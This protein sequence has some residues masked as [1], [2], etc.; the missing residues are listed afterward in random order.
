MPST[1]NNTPRI[2][3][4]MPM[5]W[6]VRNVVYSGILERLAG[7]GIQV[8]LL[9]RGHDVDFLENPAYA[10]FSL[11]AGIE[12][13]LVPPIRV[14]LK[15]RS[16]LKQVIQS[17]FYQRNKLRGYAIYRRW[18]ERHYTPFQRLRALAVE[19]LGWLAKPLLIF[20]GLNNL[21]QRLY[22]YEY[23]LPPIA[24]QLQEIAPDLI[25]STVNVDP[26][27]EPAYLLAAKDLNMPVV[28]S[29]LSFDNLTTKSINLNYL[30]YTHYLTWNEV[31][32]AQLL[33]LFPKVTEQQVTITGTPQFDFHRNP[34]FQWTRERTLARLGLKPHARFFLYA[35]TSEALAPDEPALLAELAR[36]MNRDAVLQDCW[37]VIR[38]HPSDKQARWQDALAGVEH[39]VLSQPWHAEPDPDGWALSTPEDHSL[40]ISSL[41][42]CEACL[43]I[44]S[45]TTL[46]AAILD[47]PAIG[48]RFEC[49][50][51]APREILYEE[52]DVEH[53]KPLV[54]SGGLQVAHTWSELVSL[55]QQAISAAGADK[56]LR[57]RMVERECGI[58][59]G[60]AAE[61]VVQALMD[62]LGSSSQK[63]S[64]ID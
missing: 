38:Y 11:A 9:V 55:M 2:A 64:G 23:H 16:L 27:S 58:V 33:T 20:Q 56:H 29:I 59:D 22:R 21:Y 14:R 36:R 41:V 19:V 63:G 3:V 40:F 35:G 51:E 49:E 34:A 32:R 4:L 57:V 39:V 60:L 42:H 10:E 18:L 24:E 7:L 12:P 13:L 48:I 43:N 50:D 46:D 26:L 28:T 25:W 1:T 30:S 61:R 8:Y 54:D 5:G 45:T 47:R 37:L 15:G 44:A 17:A 53:F 62:C 52:Y 6:S 31:M